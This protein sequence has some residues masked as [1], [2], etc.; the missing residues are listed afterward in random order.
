[1]FGTN[2]G[3][4]EPAGFVLRQHDH[5]PG[6]VGEPVKGI[7]APAA[8]TAARR[9]PAPQKRLVAA[10]R[11]SVLVQTH[12][13]RQ[14]RGKLSGLQ[15]PCCHVVH[16]RPGPLRRV[17][18]DHEPVERQKLRRGHQRDLLVAMAQRTMPQ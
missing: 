12:P 14:P 2:V 18:I 5:H 7:P 4:A 13:D 17:E 9:Q 16:H 8:P 11:G 3:V 10:V 1:V 6:P 15:P